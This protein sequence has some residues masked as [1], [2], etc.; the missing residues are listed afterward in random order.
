MNVAHNVIKWAVTINL[1]LFD[2]YMVHGT[3]RN[4]VHARGLARLVCSVPLSALWISFHDDSACTMQAVQAVQAVDSM[5]RVGL[6]PEFGLEA[7]TFSVIS[8]AEYTVGLKR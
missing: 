7:W 5:R 6:K 2:K 8:Y 4:K 3:H 1:Y